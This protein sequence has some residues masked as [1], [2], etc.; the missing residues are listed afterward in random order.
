MIESQRVNMVIVM[1]VE[2]R[3]DI[4]NKY[5]SYTEVSITICKQNQSLAKDKSH[6][7]KKNYLY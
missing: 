7:F 1:K 4:E 3:N 6:N 2:F 5:K